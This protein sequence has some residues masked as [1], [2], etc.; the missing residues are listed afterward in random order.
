MTEFSLRSP[1]NRTTDLDRFPDPQASTVSPHRPGTEAHASSNGVPKLNL[2]A[3]LNGANGNGVEEADA[4]LR[5]QLEMQSAAAVLAQ[6]LLEKQ[7]SLADPEVSIN[8]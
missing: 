8:E 5:V 4:Q 6:R 7:I 3:L 2:T 1:Q